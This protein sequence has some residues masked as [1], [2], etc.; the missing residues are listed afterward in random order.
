MAGMRN[1]IEQDWLRVCTV[2]QSCCT[3]VELPGEYATNGAK[4]IAVR[5]LASL[6]GPVVDTTPY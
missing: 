5:D 6:P 1:V 2:Q 4:M 3:R